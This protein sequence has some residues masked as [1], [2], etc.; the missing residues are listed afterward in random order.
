LSNLNFIKSQTLPKRLGLG[1]FKWIVKNS[2]FKVFSQNLKLKNKE[3]I[4]ELNQLR[5]EMTY[6]EISHLIGFGVVAIYSLVIFIS[7]ECLFEL[8]MMIVNVFMNLYPSLLQQE[9]KKRI[10]RLI[11]KYNYDVAL[12]CDGLHMLDLG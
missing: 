3:G 12:S 10:D 11:E 5:Q 6:S 7:G 2:F 1:Y 9:N 8:I 4:T